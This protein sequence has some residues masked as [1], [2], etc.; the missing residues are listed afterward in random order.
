MKFCT[1]CRERKFLDEFSISKQTSDGYNYYCKKCV[2]K[3][4]RDWYSRKKHDEVYM[5]TRREFLR[6]R[7]QANKVKAIEYMGG[8]CL[9]CGGVFDPCVYDFHHENEETK[10]KNP[11]AFLGRSTF[12]K[13]K[14]EL[15]KCVLL[16]ANCHRL[17]HFKEA[18]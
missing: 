9:D 10:E 5:E 15:D 17:R 7:A 12:E 8:E 18:A 3:K 2:S 16:C 6:G 1:K 13:A 14:P 4:T 11:S